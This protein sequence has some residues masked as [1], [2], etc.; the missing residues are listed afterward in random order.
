[1]KRRDQLEQ[2]VRKQLEYYEE[3]P[4]PNLWKRIELSI[5]VSP[6]KHKS[7]WIWWL[8][9]GSFLL[10]GLV[11]WHFQTINHWKN[12]VA[13]KEIAISELQQEMECLQQGTQTN[14]DAVSAEI[15]KNL[16]HHSERVTTPL[17]REEDQ[18]KMAPLG[19]TPILSNV[20]P[21]HEVKAVIPLVPAFDDLQPILIPS[22]ADKKIT[23]PEV[24]GTQVA[25]I[26]TRA[27]VPSTNLGM[28]ALGLKPSLPQYKKQWSLGIWQ[29]ATNFHDDLLAAFKHRR[30]QGE[31]G[32]PPSFYINNP[33]GTKTGGLFAEL[34]MSPKWSLRTGIAYKDQR[35]P[36]GGDLVFAYTLDNS[37]MNALGH[38]TRP[39]S[40]YNESYN[41]SISTIIANTLSNGQGAL[42]PGELFEMDFHAYQQTLYLSFPV[43]LSYHMGKTRLKHHARAGLVWN[44][45]LQSR[46]KIRY[47]S[48]SFSQ[49]YYQGHAINDGTVQV[50]YLDIGMS[51]GVEYAINQR[52]NISIDGLMY[53]S[54][55]PI[56]DQR[57]FALG[58][59][60]GLKYQF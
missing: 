60:A 39:Y 45:L 5:P 36:L 10:S 12:K 43:W 49:L 35:R 47:L 38:S 8:V 33:V 48:F 14:S 46:S 58:F 4:C 57:P 28:I 18:I 16:P 34:Q 51:Y 3:Q 22:I 1:M 15:S 19:S 59:G 23:V 13:A 29:E 55:T 24:L 2:F 17:N 11:G 32:S 25:P 54:V 41:I 56:F 27:L 7:A 50:G 53:K 6:K 20:I 40:Y 9:L 26:K 37:Q 44:G 52:F 42:E 21:N 30:S 31:Q